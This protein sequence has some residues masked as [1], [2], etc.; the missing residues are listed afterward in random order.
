MFTEANRQNQPFETSL[1][2]DPDFSYIN[3]VQ[4]DPKYSKR[5]YLNV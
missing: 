2:F 4:D 3:L 1:N 5:S